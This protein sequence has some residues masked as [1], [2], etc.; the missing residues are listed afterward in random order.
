MSNR[1]LLADDFLAR[2]DWAGARR[3]PLAGD[4]SN[5]RYLRLTDPATGET[6]VLMDAPPER[7]EDVRPFLR[8]ARHLDELGLSAPRIIAAEEETGFILLED[9]GDDLFARHLARHPEAEDTLYEAATDLLVELHR[10]PPPAGLAHYDATRMTE[11]AALAFTKYR[12][13]AVGDD[14]PQ[15]RA[16]FAPLFEDILLGHARGGEVLVLRDFHAE[17]LI[18]LPHRAD[19][20]RVGLLDFQDAMAGHA[21][22]DLVSLLQDARRDVPAMIEARMIDR[23]VDGAGCD[24][25][26]FRVAYAVLGAQRNLRILGVFARLG[27]EYGKPHYVDLIPRVWDHLMRDL[28]HPALAPVADL[29]SAALP[30]P[31]PETLAALRTGC[32]TP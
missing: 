20:R 26:G 8:I 31:T 6:A 32:P 23:Y 7:G 5:R 28:D 25:H 11:L 4:A 3:A 10:A 15:E 21:A 9:L 13:H 12:A 19:V 17:N 22:Y 24:A 16:R 18:W 30:A 1:D 27:V 29:V 14:A 2:T